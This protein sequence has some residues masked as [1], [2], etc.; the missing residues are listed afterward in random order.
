MDFW[1]VQFVN[2]ILAGTDLEQLVVHVT[3]ISSA[4]LVGAC[5]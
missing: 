2:D 4:R 3:R 5:V 1:P